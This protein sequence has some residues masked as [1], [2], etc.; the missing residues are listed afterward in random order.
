MDT[1]ALSIRVIAGHLGCFHV[2]AIVNNAVINIG[3]H[4]SFQIMVFSEYM[5]KS[6]IAGS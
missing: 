1:F 6:G 5:S 2:L 4:A 3:M